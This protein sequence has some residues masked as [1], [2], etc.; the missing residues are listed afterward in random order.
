MQQTSKSYMLSVSYSNT[1]LDMTFIETLLT[2]NKEYSNYNK[3][4]PK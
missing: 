4:K 3:E 1:I 2:D